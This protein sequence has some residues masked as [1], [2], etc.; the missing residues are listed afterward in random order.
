[1]AASTTPTMESAPALQQRLDAPQVGATD[2]SWRPLYRVGGAAALLS[3]AIVAIA[4]IVFVA[5]PP[6]PTVQGWFA[7]FQRNAVLGLLDLDLLLV[8]SY[9]VLVPFYLA[10]YVALRG[11]SPSFMLLALAFNL[12]GAALI[13]AVNPGAA[14]ITLSGQYAGATTASE[15]ATYLAAGQALMANWSG[16]AFD[17]GYLLGAFG[18]LITAAVMLRGTIFSKPIAYIGL[19]MGALMLVPASAGTVGLLLSLLSLVPTSLWLIL[20][21]RRLFQLG[22]GA[23][24]EEAHLVHRQ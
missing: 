2:A 13:L 16:T 24:A 21:A 19:V 20:I 12:L 9:V 23:S 7:L 22:Q 10:L 8:T 3:V 4:V 15:R 14:M 1:M 18:V 17:L 11:V 6:P 5:W